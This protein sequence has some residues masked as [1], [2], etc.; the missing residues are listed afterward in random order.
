MTNLESIFKSRDITLPTKVRLVKAMVFPVV[1]YGYES[2]TMKKVDHWRIDAFES[3]Y[4]RRL[5][6]VTW[7]ARSSKQSIK[8]NQSWIVIG[9]TDAETETTILWPPD[10]KN[11][12]IGKDPDA[13]K[14]WS[15]ETKGMTEDEM[16]GWNH[17][18]LVMS[19]SKLWELVMYRE[20]WCAAVLESQR[21][22]HDWAT[23]LG[24]KKGKKRRKERKKLSKIWIKMIKYVKNGKELLKSM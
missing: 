15:Q 18:L 21:V 11:G 1:M 20:V 12:L 3:C 16:V 22:R 19:L 13:G 17:W 23:E 10:A 4:W 7:T 24:W 2:W 14:N 6:R 9:R 8:E 5:F